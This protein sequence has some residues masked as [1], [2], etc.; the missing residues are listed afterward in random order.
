MYSLI[1]VDFNTLETTLNYIVHCRDS[2]GA[3]ASHVVIVENG[4]NDG[5]LELLNRMLGPYRIYTHPSLP[6]PMYC[7]QFDTQQIVYCHSG[8]NIG[9]A[10][11]NNLG[12]KIS[13]LIF[14]DEFYIISNNDLV[15]P[16]PLDLTI[17]ERLFAEHPEIG[18]I[19]PSVVTPQ[20]ERQSPNHWQTA[21]E[22]LILFYWKPV[23][24]LLRINISALSQPVTGR[25]DWVSGCFMIIRK[26]S[27]H[28]A[29]L[30]DENT[31]LYA[32]E[33]ILGRRLEAI[34][35]S[36]W[37]CR[38]LEVIHQHAQTT[39]KVLS[40][41]RGKEINFDS[42]W[43]YYNNYTDA[44]TFVLTLAKVNFLLHKLIYLCIHGLK[45]MLHI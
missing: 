15:F 13:D 35:C 5:T 21:F 10:R 3:G 22:R 4:N 20:G 16:A 38:E 17:P 41:I 25:C 29:G 6:Q 1:L 19:G 18:I 23:L 36:V 33:L 45:K 39:K 27:L 9:Y 12:I 8:G 31:F 11:G 26:D 30:F 32:E 40:S 43:Y 14:H 44:S 34:G 24:R 2:L 7:Y 28:S 42:I 37:F